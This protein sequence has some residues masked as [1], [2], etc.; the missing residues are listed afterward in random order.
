MCETKQG[1][2]KIDFLPPLLVF[3]KKKER[4]R[5]LIV[6]QSPVFVS[7]ECYTC[8]CFSIFF[9]LSAKKQTK[10]T[11]TKDSLHHFIYLHE[12]N[13]KCVKREKITLHNKQ[14]AKFTLRKKALSRQI[15][16]HHCGSR[17]LKSGYLK[18]T[19]NFLLLLFIYFHVS[20][21]YLVSLFSRVYRPALH[22]DSL[23]WM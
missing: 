6:G 15:L 11:S 22:R 19:V 3:K 5:R 14:S 9:F 23:L 20:L 21:F 2:K 17:H 18:A 10:N 12:M 4:N 16:V 8:S 13:T 7:F 1:K